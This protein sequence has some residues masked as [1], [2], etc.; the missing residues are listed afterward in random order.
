MNIRSVS[1]LIIVVVLLGCSDNDNYSLDR[2]IPRLQSADDQIAYFRIKYSNGRHIETTFYD[3]Y[4]RILEIFNFGRSS[5]KVLNRYIGN[6]LTTTIRYEHGDSS[7][8]GYISI[9]T[10][11]RNYSSH[12]RL[13]MNS[14]IKGALSISG[15]V[16]LTEFDIQ[17][18]GYTANGD[19]IIIKRESSYKYDSSQVADINKWERDDKHR[20]KSYFRL[21][22]IQRNTELLP[23]TISHY[24]QQ[25]AYDG[26]GR[27][28]V[29][30]FDHMY[31]G[32]FYLT[33]GP[34]TIKYYYDS[35]NRLLVEEHRYTNDMHNKQ[36][37]NTTG[38]PASEKESA[39]WRR[40][41][42]FNSSDNNRIDSIKYHYEEYE[43]AR[44]RSLVIPKVD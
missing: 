19:T 3:H 32:Q 14:N 24:S 38:L 1:I 15:P 11:K 2:S 9:D 17:Y 41:R 44:H 33:A 21:Y 35:Q 7:E 40:N 43:A 28:S 22:V 5:S 8:P 13:V 26:Y 16:G 37:V 42:F 12:G 4:D 10:L 27:L 20:L 23:D 29:A 39:E 6:F 18:L 25:Y 36:E 31:L 34:D 30:W